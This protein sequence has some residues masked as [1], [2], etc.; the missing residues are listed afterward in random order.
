MQVIHNPGT[1]PD[2]QL[3]RIRPDV[4]AV[5]EE[6]FSRYR[7]CGKNERAALDVYDRSGACYILH[8]VPRDQV[9]PLV[10]ELRPRAEYLFVTDRRSKFY[11]GFGESWDDFIRAMGE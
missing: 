2:E 1:I 6:G 9:K 3:T 10:R 11:E 8:S 5:F 7:A 4:T